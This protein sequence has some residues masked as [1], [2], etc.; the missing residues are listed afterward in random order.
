[1]SD[2]QNNKDKYILPIISNRNSSE[3]MHRIQ[4]KEHFATSSNAGWMEWINSFY[5]A[6]E[7]N[8]L[9]LNRCRCFCAILVLTE[10]YLL[11][12]RQFYVCFCSTKLFFRIISNERR[13][14]LSIHFKLTFEIFPLDSKP[15][16]SFSKWTYWRIVMFMFIVPQVC[17]IQCAQ[18]QA[19][20]RRFRMSYIRNARN[21]TWATNFKFKVFTTNN[22]FSVSSS[23]L[24]R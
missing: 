2:A 10:W 3:W 12:Y 15:N 20:T 5:L 17:F 19:A 4:I 21:K 23:E 24:L 14:F 13:N 9:N 6:L 11:D 16:V 7:K 22:R 1:M 18:L 8:L